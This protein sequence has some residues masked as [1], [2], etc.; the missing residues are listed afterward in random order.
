ME[1][2]END[3]FIAIN[4]E[5]PPVPM[6][7]NQNNI[8]L[9]LNE[10][11]FNLF[12]NIPNDK[13]QINNNNS[14]QINFTENKNQQNQFINMSN[15]YNNNYQQNLLE[16]QM[17]MMHLQRMNYLNYMNQ[18][19]MRNNYI[20][21]LN[22]PNNDIKNPF[23]LNKPNYDIKYPNNNNNNNSTFCDLIIDMESELLKKLSKEHLIDIILFLRDICKIKIDSKLTNL[24]HEAF[25]VKK[26]KYKLNEYK[27]YIK[28]NIIKR[29]PEIINKNKENNNDENKNIIK[30]ENI[31]NDNNIMNIQKNENNSNG[32]F[33]QI[34][35]RLYLSKDDYE[36][37]IKTHIKCEIC[38]LEFKFKKQLK[39]HRKSHFNNIIE[40]N[41]LEKNNNES[42]KIEIL[43]QNLNPNEIKC[44]DCDLVFN[45][46]EQMSSHHYNIHQVKNSFNIFEFQKNINEQTKIKDDIKKQ[47]EKKN[48][49]EKVQNQNEIKDLRKLQNLEKIK[50]EEIKGKKDIKVR[51][52]NYGFCHDGK[53]FESEE[54]Y[55]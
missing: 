31:I 50:K 35:N 1:D 11:N 25:N 44:T 22:K 13:V 54:D 30:E 23:N 20:N 39:R 38:G 24:R 3:E 36:N 40:K 32:Y 2:K 16:N 27:L 52:N 33:C 29:R 41:N 14:K 9:N 17:Y 34:H 48:K 12:H 4:G 18:L 47:E 46:F 8:N 45:S 6:I 55:I 10:S 42:E 26:N 21:N 19:Q 49:I 5:A 7:P 37:H 28:S 15:S 51:E 53:E 43:K